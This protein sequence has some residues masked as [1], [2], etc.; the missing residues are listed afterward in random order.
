[1]P[2]LRRKQ[3]KNFRLQLGVH[4]MLTCSL[5]RNL[6]AEHSSL[7]LY[8]PLLF[9]KRHPSLDLESVQNPRPEM[10]FCLY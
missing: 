1:M 4:Q 9:E 10:R 6:G 3:A 5:I 8:L 7:Y 2:A